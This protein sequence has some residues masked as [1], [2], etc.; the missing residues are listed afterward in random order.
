[1][2]KEHLTWGEHLEH[3]EDFVLRGDRIL[4]LQDKADQFAGPLKIIITPDTAKEVPQRGTILKLGSNYKTDVEMG[5]LHVGQSV[6][7]GKYAGSE[8]DIDGREYFIARQTD[9]IGLKKTIKFDL[10]SYPPGQEPS[11]KFPINKESSN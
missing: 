8:I 6:W 5:D 1:M 2:E 4:L 7:Y 10:N 11:K 3:I 9:I